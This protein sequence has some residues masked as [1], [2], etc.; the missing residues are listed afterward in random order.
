MMGSH[1]LITGATGYLGRALLNS[2]KPADFSKIT[3]VLRDG[4]AAPKLGRIN[5]IT[6]S[7]LLNDLNSLND[8]DIICH[9][10][11]S[12]RNDN[13]GDLVQELNDLR[14]LLTKASH[15]N[16]SGF[17]LASSQAVYGATEPPWTETDILSPLTPH[18]WAK[19]GGEQL[20]QLIQT[21]TP[22]ISCCALRIPKLIGPGPRFRID[23]GE[24]PHKLALSALQQ[25]PI[26]ISS[27][28]LE[29]KFD[30]MDVRDAASILYSIIK[31]CPSTWPNVLNIG[32]GKFFEGRD[33]VVAVDNCSRQR[34]AKGINCEPFINNKKPRDFGMCVTRLIEYMPNTNFR[35]LNETIDDVF[36]YLLTL[37]ELRNSALSE[38]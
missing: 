10:A 35:T 14:C 37:R 19:I 22:S 3:G 24:L 30:F 32:T 12:R 16:V 8:V 25:K 38:I 21:V 13:A 36:S 28:A 11:S 15:S 6:H 33:I 4:A 23:Q 34:F 1:I 29:Q 20:L 26:I 31:R 17:I 7:D 27:N 5:W 18:G 2:F 9:L